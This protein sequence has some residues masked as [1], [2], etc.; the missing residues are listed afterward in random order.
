MTFEQFK[1]LK[2]SE[3]VKP[4]GSLSHNPTSFLIDMLIN[5]IKIKNIK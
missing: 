4:T 3:Y 1:S 2:E 5:Y